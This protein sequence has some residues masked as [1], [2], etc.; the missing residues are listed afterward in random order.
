MPI[1]Q[2]LYLTS[3]RSLAMSSQRP[4]HSSRSFAKLYGKD[5]VIVIEKGDGLKLKYLH[6]DKEYRHNRDYT[7]EDKVDIVKKKDGKTLRELA[8]E[9]GVPKS[10]LYEWDKK[11]SK[12]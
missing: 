1:S 4:Y 3:I 5:N 12:K 10:T 6:C 7:E 8:Q 11:F 2:C 9:T